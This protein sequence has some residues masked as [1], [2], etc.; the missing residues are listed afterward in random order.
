MFNRLPPLVRVPARYGVI[1]GV[2]AFIQLLAFFYMNRHPFLI[3]VFFDFRIILF[4]V[5]LFFCLKEL[6]GFY[7][8][9]LLFFWQGMIASL[10]FTIV[11]AT[12][13]SSFL[14]LFCLFEPR[15]VAEYIE[16]AISQ[17][18]TFPAEVIERI[19]K[20]VYERN[21]AAL[22][23][24]NAFDLVSLYF[25]QSFGI[26]FFISIIVSVVLRQQPKYT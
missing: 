16:L 17:I 4:A 25:V 13:A 9:G 11:F 8:Q 5:L 3:P 14:W 2:I 24:T 20:E 1:G 6:R 7:F 15:F 19:G 22:P 23:A 18:R 12:I 26:S 21:L 10:L